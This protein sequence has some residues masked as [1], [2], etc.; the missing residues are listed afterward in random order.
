[1][2]TIKKSNCIDDV[3]NDT[4]NLTSRDGLGASVAFWRGCVSPLRGCLKSEADRLAIYQVTAAR[5]VAWHSQVPWRKLIATGSLRCR[6]RFFCLKS[7][8]VLGELCR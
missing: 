2:D 8:S 3:D 4:I 1:M 7:A 5:F 6:G